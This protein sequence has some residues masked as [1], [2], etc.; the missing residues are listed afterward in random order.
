MMHVLGFNQVHVYPTSKQSYLFRMATALPQI[1]DI[2]SG[3]TGNAY[4][5]TPPR[6]GT[7]KSRPGT[8]LSTKS[9]KL[10]NAS[11]KEQEII[12]RREQLRGEQPA[13]NKA[14]TAS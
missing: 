10:K 1:R 4:G 12:L 14:Q 5:P 8:G 9:L 3:K 11:R 6:T 7:P 13:L 2:R